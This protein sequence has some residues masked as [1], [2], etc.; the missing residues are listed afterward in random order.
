MQSDRRLWLPWLA[1]V[2]SLLV[3][4]AFWFGRDFSH[5]DFFTA[6]IASMR[7]LG[8]KPGRDFYLPS[9]LPAAELL[10]PLF[11]WF[12]ESFL[13]LDI[14]RALVLVLSLLLLSVCWRLTREIGGSPA[15]AV[16]AVLIVT[17]QSDFVAR[18]ADIR[19]EPVAALFLLVSCL[20]ILQGRVSWSGVFFGLALA[21]AYKYVVAGPFLVMALFLRGGRRLHSFFRFAA[22]SIIAPAAYFGWRLAADGREVFLSVVHET[23]ASTR[24]VGSDKAFYLGRSFSS[25]WF[26]LILIAAGLTAAIWKYGRRREGAPVAAYAVL[27]TTF[28]IVYVAINPF[29]FPYTAVLLVPILAPLVAGLSPVIEHIR[30]RNLQ[31]SAL[32]AATLCIAFQGLP[33]VVTTSQRTNRH[34]RQVVRWIWRN[35][36]PD[37]HVFDWQGMHFGRPG[38]FHWYQFGA[39]RGRYEQG[40]YSLADEWRRYGIHLLIDNFRFRYMKPS[41]R[42]FLAT[43]FV[44]I[45]QCLLA[46]G[47]IFNAP[48]VQKGVLFDAVAGGSYQTRGGPLFID[49]RL[50]GEWT[51]LTAGPHTISRSG[52]PAAG[53]AGLVLTTPGAKR[54]PMPCPP[55]GEPLLYGLD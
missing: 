37:D 24:A 40:W 53:P 19:A 29:I 27:A 50:T 26:S 16:L 12:P 42:D 23:A 41:D 49:G 51:T 3:R 13:P 7:A 25:S 47:G 17:W 18:I 9:F 8:A 6:Y 31:L 36:R 15:A 34:Q 43:H 20:A 10:A 48:A 52:S 39:I 28:S 35:T 45:D 21:M 11:R 55:I 5:D 44:K 14:A 38:I 1:V 2:A 4:V 30:H 54:D 33:A 46:P 32:A 22:F